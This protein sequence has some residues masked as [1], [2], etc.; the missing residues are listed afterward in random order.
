M[1]TCLPSMWLGVVSL[2]HLL[3]LPL[4]LLLASI[5]LV[6]LTLELRDLRPIRQNR[7]WGSLHIR[8]PSAC[9]CLN[10]VVGTQLLPFW[11]ACRWPESRGTGLLSSWR[12][13]PIFGSTTALDFQSALS[14]FEPIL[15]V[16][17][18]W[19]YLSCLYI[20]WV[21]LRMHWRKAWCSAP[22]R[23]WHYHFYCKNR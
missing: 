8:S 19:L 16:T 22:S 21:Y 20:F 17:S 3:A 23:T 5:T 11:A 18:V 6:L 7:T 13:Q 10:H 15:T 12:C 14:W 4:Q 1:R 2:L 9:A